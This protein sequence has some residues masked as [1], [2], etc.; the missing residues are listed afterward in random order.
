[1]KKEFYLKNT[2][3]NEILIKSILNVLK[4]VNITYKKVDDFFIVSI[5]CE[6]CELLIDKIKNKESKYILLHNFLISFINQIK[7]LEKNKYTF[8]NIHTE[9][10][11]LINNELSICIDEEIIEIVGDK[12]KINNIFKK[13]EYCSPELYDINDLPNKITYKSVYF[14]IGIFLLKN[15]VEEI[16][17]DL[18][19]QLKK[20]DK[21]ENK[22]NILI[23][24]DKKLNEIKYT[25]MYFFIKKNI[26]IAESKRLLIYI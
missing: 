12:I 3:E 22:I 23:K 13:N 19:Y 24:I 8:Y 16:E 2:K 21:I 25:K 10:F 9:K 7:F 1:M 15:L 18:F 6:S 26:N 20:E 11:Y 4:N 14:S 17:E 5:I